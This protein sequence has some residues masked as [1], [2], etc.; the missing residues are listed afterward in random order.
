MPCHD[1]PHH[2]TS[3][4]GDSLA[5]PA[6]VVLRSTAASAASAACPGSSRAHR[7]RRPGPRAGDPQT[8]VATDWGHRRDPLRRPH[9][10]FDEGLLGGLYQS[11]RS[12]AAEDDP[13]RE[14]QLGEDDWSRRD[15]PLATEGLPGILPPLA[16]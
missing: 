5:R 14:E 3:H 8:L 9:P 15:L 10:G 1:F 12:E 16:E 13:G 2:S 7:L 6:D 11:Y 4:R